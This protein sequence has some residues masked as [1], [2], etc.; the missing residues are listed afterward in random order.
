MHEEEFGEISEQDI[1][2][3]MKALKSKLSSKSKAAHRNALPKKEFK[4]TMQIFYILFLI[5]IVL[6]IFICCWIQKTIAF[7]P[8]KD[9]MRTIGH[10]FYITIG[11]MLLSTAILIYN[12]NNKMA[13]IVS[14]EYFEYTSRSLYLEAPWETVIFK[15]GSNNGL[16]KVSI[17]IAN[18]KTLYI[19]NIFFPK[20]YD[21]LC[22]LME[23]AVEPNANKVF[24]L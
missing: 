13:I 20:K 11:I 5:S 10:I 12:R 3:K 16:Y 23:M 9:V 7:L 4:S 22:K 2:G 8:V 14:P 1:E 24:H 21:T 15:K 17:I 6:Y 19:D 18:K